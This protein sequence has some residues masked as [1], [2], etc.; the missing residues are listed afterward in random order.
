MSRILVAASPVPRS[1]VKRIL[2]GHE[3]VYAGT[4][5]EAEQFLD[6][7]TF[8]LIVCTIAFDDSRMFDFLRLAK[9]KAKWARI[10]FVC[11]RV[12]RATL[13]SAI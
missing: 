2:A 10:P 9:S 6:R 7:P 11:A 13:D 5:D 4:M 1:I 8:D 3:L 12:R